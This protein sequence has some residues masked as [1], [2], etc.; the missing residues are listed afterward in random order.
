MHSEIDEYKAQ[1]REQ[2][3]P[4]EGTRPV[5]KPILILIAVVLAWAI[6]YIAISNPKDAPELGDRRTLTALNGPAPAVQGAAVDGAQVFAAQCVACHQ[7]TGLGI[8]GAFPPL[9]ASEWVLGSPKVLAKILLHGIQGNLTVAGKPYAGQMPPF[10]EKLN[11]AEIAAV[12]SHIRS[13][14]GNSA[15]PLEAAL[16]AD[17][18]KATADRPGPWNGDADLNALPKD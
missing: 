2:R 10:K 16:V 5:P 12:A 14:W 13:Q 18:R 17:A 8:A 4:F 6:V 15:A 9:A 3:E 11:D 1:A 7:A